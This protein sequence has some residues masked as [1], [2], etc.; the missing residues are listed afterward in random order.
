M[1][2]LKA[3][4]TPAILS[5]LA[6]LP[7]LLLLAV[8]MPNHVFAQDYRSSSP[9]RVWGDI[10]FLYRNRDVDGGARTATQSLNTARINASSYIWRPWFAT[11][12]GGLTFFDD[13][14]KTSGQ[15]SVESDF[16]TG[17]L[18]FSLFPGSRFPFQFSYNES[19]NQLDSNFF[20]RETVTKEYTVSQQYR[21]RNKRNN[22]RAKLRQNEREVTGVDSTSF[23]SLFLSSGHSFTNQSLNTEILLDSAENASRDQQAESY[24]VTGRHAYS[25]GSNLSVENLVSTSRVENSFLQS[26]SDTDTAQISSLLLWR[27]GGRNDM[28]LTGGLRLSELAVND[29]SQTGPAAIQ[30]SQAES[31][32]ANINQSFVYNYSER[33]LLSQ[34]ASASLIESG[35]EEEFFASESLAIN[36]SSDRL[37]LDAGD[38]GWS[39]GSSF[40]NQHGDVESTQ[41]LSN[42]FSHSL[43]SDFSVRD[44]YQLRTNMTQ[45]LGQT[46]RTEQ[47]DQKSLNHAFSVT[48]SE[49][50]TNDR[51]LI[52]F[53]V[54][55]SRTLDDT[56]NTFRLINLQYSG[57]LRFSRYANLT[58][59][60]TLQKS[61]QVN[62]NDRRESMVRNGQLQFIRNRLFQLPRLQF[63]STLRLSQRQSENERF[64]ANLRD[65][66]DSESSWENALQ[67]RIG[68]LE[69]EMKLDYIK[70]DGIVDR[71]FRI[72]LTRSFGDL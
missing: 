56:E 60:I 72:Q 65:D 63:R 18:R 31:S 64:L 7:E 6:L 68:R 11:M 24:S 25:G 43:S 19:R 34:S 28:R 61:I 15:G 66:T 26:E 3:I 69:A 50:S 45:S 55:D 22:Y 23:E 8:F 16:L 27:P 20:E 51:S 42:R 46:S 21:S 9:V 47:Q 54:S 14:N 17:N 1:Y 40:N 10:S 58:G 53:S 13:R 5:V 35:I 32:T 59:D 49:S 30:Q 36:Y 33:L 70:R 67:Y 39:V 71:L 44:Q 4:K 62:E 57:F 12:D 38:Y 29:R 41:S 48:W 37:M 2:A 52:R